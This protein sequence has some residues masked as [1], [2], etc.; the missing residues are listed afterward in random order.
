LGD[1]FLTAIR[2]L[3]LVLKEFPNAHPFIRAPYRRLIVKGFPFA[4]VFRVDVDRM[5]LWLSLI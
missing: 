4:V 5:L 3:F 2:N 1:R